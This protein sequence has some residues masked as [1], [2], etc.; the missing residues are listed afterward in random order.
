MDEPTTFEFDG[1]EYTRITMAKDSWGV[2]PFRDAL[3]ILERRNRQV[4]ELIGYAE[5]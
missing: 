5:W 3:R 1:K 2:S 4:A